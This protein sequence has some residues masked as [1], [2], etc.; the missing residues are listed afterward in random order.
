MS[1]NDQPTNGQPQHLAEKSTPVFLLQLFLIPG[2]IVIIC[3][4]ILLLFTWLA[5]GEK[6]VKD[7]INEVRTE[8]GNSRWQAAY[9]LSQV[10]T[11]E[12]TRRTDPSVVPALVELLTDSLNRPD[13]EVR[14]YLVIALGRL[15]D[16][17]AAQVLIAA[18]GDRDEQTKIY[19]IWALGALGSVEAVPSIIKAM[20]DE[21]GG[22]R[23]MAAYTLGVLKDPSVTYTLRTALNDREEDVRWNAALALAQVG[24]SSGFSV[25]QAMMNRG[26]LNR[27]AEMSE[28]RKVEAITNAIKAVVLLREYN[29]REQLVAISKSDPNLKVRQAA[30]DAL[31]EMR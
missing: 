28:E 5:G 8:R 6:T 30:M 3:V 20:E 7:Y 27:I 12:K 11:R 17:Q 2:V 9:E 29:Q 4:A 15:A 25:I 16:K 1:T 14:R 10:L 19:A 18:L 24:D 13:P 23:K 21:S 31:A 22:V 26:Y